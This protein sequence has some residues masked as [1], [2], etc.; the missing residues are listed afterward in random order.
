[1]VK[2]LDSEDETEMLRK[3]EG[4][5][6]DKLLAAH[7]AGTKSLNYQEITEQISSP[8][9][10]DIDTALEDLVAQALIHSSDGENY[11]ISNDGISER[12]KRKTDGTLF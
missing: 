8:H 11:Y 10:E 3:I 9:P 1:M 4:M 6:L 2:E 12:S 5:V 7:S